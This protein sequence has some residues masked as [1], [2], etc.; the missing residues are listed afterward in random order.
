MTAMPI[1]Q[2]MDLGYRF[3]CRMAE[4]MVAGDI[5]V[6]FHYAWPEMLAIGLFVIGYDFYRRRRRRNR[7][8]AKVSGLLFH[9][10]KAFDII[11]EYADDHGQRKHVRYDGTRWPD[12]A[13]GTPVRLEVSE[14]TGSGH[15]TEEMPMTASGAFFIAAALPYA[16]RDV[17]AADFS[18]AAALLQ[19]FSSELILCVAAAALQPLLQLSN[20][21][22]RKGIEDNV[23]HVVRFEDIPADPDRFKAW[24]RI[25][26]ERRRGVAGFFLLGLLVTYI[27]VD[28]WRLVATYPVRT[29]TVIAVDT[30]ARA[31]ALWGETEKHVNVYTLRVVIHDPAGD[32]PYMMFRGLRRPALSPGD[33]VRVRD[34]NRFPAVVIDEGVI[35]PALEPVVLIV[36]AVLIFLGVRRAWWAQTRGS[37]FHAVTGF[38]PPWLK[39]S[40]A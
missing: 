16:W 40:A 37:I 2:F 8:D 39:G 5:D 7:V 4:I 25:M 9:K 18:L 10:N 31:Y 33:T 38:E 30:E 19:L 6:A 12:L 29:A 1:E 21:S 22:A 34:I 36:V 28:S 26:N 11:C 14:D 17:S 24:N 27:A 35:E 20:W 32:I 23:D 3:L 13:T 15:I